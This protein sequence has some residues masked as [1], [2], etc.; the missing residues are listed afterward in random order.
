MEA[1]L[2]RARATKNPWPV[3]CDA[4]M[5]PVDFEKCLWFQKDQIH[6]M[7]PEGASTCR[8]KSAKGELVEKVYDYAIAGNSLKGE[9][10]QMKVVEDLEPRPHKAVSFVVERGKE[11]QEWNEQKLPK[12][13]PGYSGGRLPGSSM[14]E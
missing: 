14:K 1:V 7:A 3:A 12:V 13:L 11:K 6:V 4:N 10:S 5:S 8:S 9:I 2:E